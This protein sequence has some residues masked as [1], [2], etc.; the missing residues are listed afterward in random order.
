MEGIIK[1][2]TWSTGIG[3]GDSVDRIIGGGDD[4]E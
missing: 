2:M 1:R 3:G 4:D